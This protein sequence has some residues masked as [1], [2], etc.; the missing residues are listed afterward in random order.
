MGKGGGIFKIFRALFK[1]GKLFGKGSGGAGWLF[2]L[3][4]ISSLFKKKKKAPEPVVA[5]TNYESPTYSFGGGIATTISSDNAPIPLVFGRHVVGGQIVNSFISSNDIRGIDETIQAS[6]TAVV[7]VSHDLSSGTSIYKVVGC[8]PLAK[9]GLSTT[10][11][12]PKEISGQQTTYANFNKNAI[13]QLSVSDDNGANYTIV[14]KVP[15]SSLYNPSAVFN[16]SLGNWSIKT[17]TV[18]IPIQTSATQ[19]IYIKMQLLNFTVPKNSSYDAYFTRTNINMDNYRFYLGQEIEVVSVLSRINDYL[20]LDKVFYSIPRTVKSGAAVNQRLYMDVVLSAGEIRNLRNVFVNDRNAFDMTT[21][22]KQG[23]VERNTKFSFRP[24]FDSVIDVNVEDT[25]EFQS[26]VFN[27]NDTPVDKLTGSLQNQ[28][29]VVGDN[30]LYLEDTT[31]FNGATQLSYNDETR[32]SLYSATITSV[33]NDYITLS[34]P[35]GS[36]VGSGA[37]WYIYKTETPTYYDFQYTTQVD[38]VD[39]IVIGL[40]AYEGLF[41]TNTETGALYNRDVDITVKI[42]HATLSD[43]ASATFPLSAITSASEILV[44]K[45]VTL[46]GAKR[47]KLWFDQT[48]REELLPNP[49]NGE[50]KYLIEIRKTTNSTFSEYARNKLQVAYVEELVNKELVYNGCAYVGMEIAAN[51]KVNN[52]TPNLRFEVDGL[53][54]PCSIPGSISIN[55]AS[56]TVSTI[57]TQFN[58]SFSTATNYTLVDTTKL[59]LSGFAVEH[60]YKLYTLLEDQAVIYGVLGGGGNLRRCYNHFFRKDKYSNQVLYYWDIYKA[61]F[62]CGDS[63]YSRFVK[64]SQEN[65]PEYPS[66]S[67][68]EHYRNVINI[69]NFA[70]ST[71]HI[72]TYFLEYLDYNWLI[73]NNTPLPS[74]P[75]DMILY[76]WSDNPAWIIL[77]LL[78]DENNGAGIPFENIDLD[79]FNE[80]AAYYDSNIDNPITSIQG[81][82]I[83]RCSVNF[84]LDSYADLRSHIEKILTICHGAL[85]NSNDKIKFLVERLV[86]DSEI[87]V[88]LDESTDLID[89]S[90]S[91]VPSKDMPN[92]LSVTFLDENDSYNKRSIVIEDTSLSKSRGYQSVVRQDIDMFGLTNESHVMMEASKIIKAGRYVKFGIQFKTALS[93]LPL[94][95]YDVFKLT[96]TTYGWVEKKFRVIDIKFSPEKEVEI[97]AIE[98][99]DDI[100]LLESDDLIKYH[101]V[102]HTNLPLL[103]EAPEPVKNLTVF[104]EAIRNNAG[105]VNVNLIGHFNS[106]QAVVFNDDGDMIED[107]RASYSK[108]AYVLVSLY[109]STTENGTYSII[110]DRVRFEG[111]EFRFNNLEIGAW[112]RVSVE[113]GSLS[114]AIGS[115]VYSSKIQ[116]DGKKLAPLNVTNATW[117]RTVSDHSRYSLRWTPNTTDFDLASVVIRFATATGDW[118]NYEYQETIPA[119]NSPFA[120]F[121][122]TP[123]GLNYANIDFGKTT[124]TNFQIMFKCLDTSGNYSS[125]TY[126]LNASATLE[127]PAPDNLTITHTNNDNDYPFTITCD[128]PVSDSIYQYQIKIGSATS[129]W[130]NAQYSFISK[131]RSY[132]I[133]TVYDIPLLANTDELNIMLKSVNS[134]LRYSTST[135]TVINL[136][137]EPTTPAGA[138]LTLDLNGVIWGHFPEPENADFRLYEYK[139][140]LNSDPTAAH[141]MTGVAFTTAPVRVGTIESDTDS[142]LIYL[143]YRALDKTAHYGAYDSASTFTFDVIPAHVSST[144]AKY[145]VDNNAISLLLPDK[146]QEASW[147]AY[148]IHISSASGFTPEINSTSTTRI[149]TGRTNQFEIKQFKDGTALNGASTYYIKFRSISKY[150][151]ANPLYNSAFSTDLTVLTADAE[152]PVLI[153]NAIT[154]SI[155]PIN[156]IIGDTLQV[157]YQVSDNGSIDRTRGRVYHVDHLASATWID[158][159]DADSHTFDLFPS[160]TDG[161][162][163]IQLTTFDT[164]GNYSNYTNYFSRDTAVASAPSAVTIS[165]TNTTG[166]M[167]EI[168]APTETINLKEYVAEYAVNVGAGYSAWAEIRRTNAT[169]F[170][171]SLAISGYV[172]FRVKTTKTHTATLDSAYTESNEMLMDTLGP[173][174]K[175]DY[176]DP[177]FFADTL[178]TADTVT[179]HFL[180]TDTLSLRMDDPVVYSLDSGVCT[181]ATTLVADGLTAASGTVVLSGLSEGAHTVTLRCY[182]SVG[183]TIDTQV[184]WFEVDTTAPAD[185]D[186]PTVAVNGRTI[187]VSTQEFTRSPNVTHVEFQIYNADTDEVV[188]T[189]RGS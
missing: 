19:D 58:P 100:Y 155:S 98:Y 47:A 73:N 119:K 180:A 137:L 51:S 5:A 179:L 52:G 146:S 17:T 41:N 95:V 44:N 147:E 169:T 34:Q 25:L 76:Q 187:T 75:E 48:F 139:V 96:S 134:K 33:E 107:S 112:Y 150:A 154:P 2:A 23:G 64:I 69:I 67:S 166:I 22:N 60:D 27:Q 71:S 176:V 141:V 12:L 170:F 135:S 66:P 28:D 45:N 56:S 59:K 35:W 90:V 101:A 140:S 70:T 113:S 145:K 127:P 24:G 116:L 102:S 132:T 172:K 138:T 65:L 108:T 104:E 29:T 39:G 91:S 156:I 21:D 14:N 20:K 79:S 188:A 37:Q 133:N 110:R 167:V 93:A 182:D 16:R 57:V 103:T 177:N 15:L 157:D 92:Q 84:I 40:N 38:N 163:V 31:V 164:Q 83:K 120:G 149:T 8:P 109:H 72:Y 158:P 54:L 118:S 151:P 171:E 61:Y 43:G 129:D 131:N 125:S 18:S 143:H 173:T 6:A 94:E 184:Y 9:E 105:N 7:Y 186:A 106:P 114:N 82:T 63:W 81:D 86:N 36:V 144:Q 55:T 99:F 183:N 4:L 62:K 148:E 50:K 3:I 181:T 136:T 89:L 161:N 80:A 87:I 32:E 97:G 117:E 130:N 53:L 185:L 1:G 174:L 121:E 162:Y 49:L 175:V 88:N 142:Q 126:T 115:P 160:S 42:V 124:D 123:Y 46:R 13:V 111:D 122:F 68:H 30:K 74:V 189:V 78:C 85:Y 159:I 77:Y 10:I 26:T 178:L 128:Q 11:I 152:N 153:V 168:T 165:Q